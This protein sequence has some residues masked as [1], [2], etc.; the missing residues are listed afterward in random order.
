VKEFIEG[1]LLFEFSERW[2]ELSH[3]DRHDAYLHGMHYSRAGK[4]VDFIGILDGKVPFFI[5]VKDFR[6]SPRNRAKPPL[7]EEFECKV[8]D[9]VAALTGAH[10]KDRDPDCAKI[11]KTLLTTRKPNVV[12][13]HEPHRAPNSQ[14]S[15]QAD[16]GILVAEIRG[17]LR[18]IPTAPSVTYLADNYNISLPGVRVSD[19]GPVRRDRLRAL[20]Q[21]IEDRSPVLTL[22]E[23]ARWQIESTRDI[24]TLETYIARC[25]TASSIWQLFKK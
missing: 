9:T 21:S 25:Q 20:Y 8:R 13:W 6:I 23:K 24:Q 2:S 19:L 7:A 5:E 17:H 22:E 11:F 18:W 16:A 1:N 14:K 4:A 15:A 12:L 10:C 3:W